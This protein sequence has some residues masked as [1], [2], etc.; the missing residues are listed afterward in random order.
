MVACQAIPTEV[1]IIG[2]Q[3]I[4]L[5]VLGIRYLFNKDVM[6]KFYGRG[7]CLSSRKDFKSY[8]LHQGCKGLY[9]AAAV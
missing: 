2:S 3:F 4:S 5:Q 9:Y 7:G 1:N 8:S 6:R